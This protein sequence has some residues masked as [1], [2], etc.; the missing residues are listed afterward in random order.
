MSDLVLTL[1]RM[2]YLVLLW[3]LV[4]SC[5]GVLRRDL[6]GTAIAQRF[7]PGRNSSDTA[8][9]SATNSNRSPAVTLAVLEGPLVG[10][11]MA[12]SSSAVLIGR[13]A[14]STLVVDDDYTSSRHARIFPHAGGWFVED[15]GSTNGTWLAGQR[16]DA[17]QRIQPGQRVKIGSTVVE[18]R[19]GG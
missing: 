3:I 13:A 8:S 19:G 10:T 7:R 15:L 16:V 4:L 18:L 11:T 17:P 2:S 6:F 12:L 9:G 1:L 14:S 5:V